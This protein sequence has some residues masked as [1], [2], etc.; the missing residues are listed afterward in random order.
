LVGRFDESIAPDLRLLNHELDQAEEHSDT[1]PWF[2]LGESVRHPLVGCDPYH[3]SQVLRNHAKNYAEHKNFEVAL[4]ILDTGLRWPGSGIHGGMYEEIAR[5]A[6]ARGR[7]D[8]AM[9]IALDNERVLAGPG[10]KNVGEIPPDEAWESQ[11]VGMA[12]EWLYRGMS[13]YR[14]A[15]EET[16]LFDGTLVGKFW[17]RVDEYSELLAKVS[18]PDGLPL[19]PDSTP[20]LNWAWVSLGTACHMLSGVGQ[21][22]RA[23]YI[24][25]L[26]PRIYDYKQ[27][28]VKIVC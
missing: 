23:E 14:A 25:G 9:A 21:E 28:S 3:V 20:A 2:V 10:P 19:T 1:P 15:R 22:Q 7:S 12:S 4:H 16:R 11:V 18:T 24:E 8:I 6:A 27:S 17:D 26:D 5:V 13:I